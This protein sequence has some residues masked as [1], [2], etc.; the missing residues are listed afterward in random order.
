MSDIPEAS[1]ASQSIQASRVL[2][3]NDIRRQYFNRPGHGVGFG[4]RRGHSDGEITQPRSRSLNTPVGNES[5]L[6]RTLSADDP[7]QTMGRAGNTPQRPDSLHEFLRNVE[8]TESVQEFLNS[9]NDGDRVRSVRARQQ[10][11]M[12]LIEQRKRAQQVRDM[13]AR[14]RAITMTSPRS[15]AVGLRRH[16]ASASGSGDF[17]TPSNPF[18]NHQSASDEP[19]SPHHPVTPRNRNDRGDEYVV[20]RWQPDSEVSSCRICHH[21]FS[22]FFRKHHC[23]KCGRVVCANCSPHRITIPQ[24]FIVR[25]PTE[26]GT[27]GATTSEDSDEGNVTLGLSAPGQ[28][29]SALGGGQEVR[30]CNPC[31]PDP[32]PLPPPPYP[33]ASTNYSTPSSSRPDAVARRHGSLRGHYA[34]QPHSTSRRQS[35]SLNALTNPTNAYDVGSRPLPNP[36]APDV[37]LLIMNSSSF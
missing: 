31:V 1:I 20:P 7:T 26:D 29:D 35:T 2:D 33:L 22:F 4:V 25:P 9:T 5:N 16:A 27:L 24:P 23:R 13:Q 3:P 10:A 34:Q 28:L 18:V 32:N 12:M 30:L 6:H 21:P 15:P 37:G 11:M 14:R 8:G 36:F 19:M 17:R